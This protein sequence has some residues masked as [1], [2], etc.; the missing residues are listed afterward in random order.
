MT[1][2]GALAT[3]RAPANADWLIRA[4]LEKAA[5]SWGKGESFK[6]DVPPE[7]SARLDQQ[8]FT[9]GTEQYSA[10]RTALKA[11]LRIG[12]AWADPDRWR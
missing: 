6:F 10:N 7:G 9:C 2:I 12:F 8:S 4:C 3:G 1:R 11:R 5:A